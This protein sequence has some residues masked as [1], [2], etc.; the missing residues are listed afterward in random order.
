[1][2]TGAKEG[3]SGGWT[4]LHFDIHAMQPSGKYGIQEGYAFLWQ[5]Y[6]ARYKPKVLA[7]ARPHH[8]IWTGQ[9]VDLDASKSWGKGLTFEWTFGDGSTAK[10][11]KV[12]RTYAKP[13]S[14]AEILKAT[15]ADGNVDVDFAVVQ[16]IDKDHP[17]RLPPTIHATYAPTN[18]IRANTPVTFKVRT[19]RTTDGGET[20]DFGDGSAPVK[21]KSDGNVNSHAPW[22]YAEVHHRYRKPGHYLV[23]V[24]RTDRHG[25]TA[26]AR[27]YVRVE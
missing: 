27:L 15:D 10:G 18:L 19:F 23:K 14:Y 6:L 12:E 13:G 21:V 25:Q 2:R 7:V 5:A 11:P 20:W 1:M 9:K 3:G 17:D 8:L 24:E 22:G 26:T 16:V 4:H